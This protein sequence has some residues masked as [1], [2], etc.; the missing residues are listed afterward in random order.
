MLGY[1]VDH[2]VNHHLKDGVPHL[3]ATPHT[4]TGFNHG[5]DQYRVWYGSMVLPPSGAVHPKHGKT[6]GELRRL[7][8]EAS[9]SGDDK[10][11]HANENLASL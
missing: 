11:K 1:G 9:L 10:D 3:R 2:F 6:F 7:M 8:I 4:L 5:K